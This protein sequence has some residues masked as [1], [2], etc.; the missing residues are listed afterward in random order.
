MFISQCAI[1]WNSMPQ[2]EL[3]TES[4]RIPLT[5]KQFKQLEKKANNEVLPT[6]TFVRSHIVKSLKLKEDPKN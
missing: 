2:K 6:A 4:I 1:L 3:L 5:P